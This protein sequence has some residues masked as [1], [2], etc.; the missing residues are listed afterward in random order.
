[1]KKTTVKNNSQKSLDNIQALNNAQL[2]QIKGGKTGIIIENEIM[3]GKV[4]III[5][6]DVMG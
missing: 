2:T 5:E 6:D 4:A 1:M 3:G